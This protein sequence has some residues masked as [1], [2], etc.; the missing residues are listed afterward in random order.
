MIRRL[1]EDEVEQVAEVLDLARLH[2][3]D[4]Y[5]LVAWE[6]GTPVGHAHIALTDHPELQDVL[7]RQDRRRRGVA[8][9]LTVAAEQEAR[10]HGADRLRLHVSE[11]DQAAQAL[12]RK[13]GYVDTGEPPERVQGTIQ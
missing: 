3:G 13:C 11:N 6:E 10:A 5:Y 4:G 9:A 8:S 1:G 2:Q 12:Y 7:V